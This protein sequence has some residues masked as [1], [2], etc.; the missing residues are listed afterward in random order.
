M[1]SDIYDEF[2]KLSVEK[3][4][5]RVVGDPFDA[6]TEQGPQVDKAQFDKILHYINLGKEQGA[7]LC[8]GRLILWD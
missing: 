5:T 2:V 3:A 4:K 6:K 7:R 1:H 8:T